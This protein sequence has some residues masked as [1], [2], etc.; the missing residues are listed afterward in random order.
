MICDFCHEEET[1]LTRLVFL[2]DGAVSCVR[3]WI[4]EELYL[5]YR[6]GEQVE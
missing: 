4:D 5:K 6:S 1:D 2:P 3:C